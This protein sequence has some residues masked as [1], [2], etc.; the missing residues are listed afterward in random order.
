MYANFE[1]C[2]KLTQQRG[3][4]EAI[5]LLLLVFFFRLFSILALLLLLFLWFFVL[6]DKNFGM[7]C[8]GMRIRART[9]YEK[10]DI[11]LEGECANLSYFSELKKQ[12]FYGESIK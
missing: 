1:I 4:G 7:S 9:R 11:S 2:L 12:V 6:L 10:K 5:S 3:K 8:E